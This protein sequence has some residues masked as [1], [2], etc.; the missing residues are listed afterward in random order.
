MTRLFINRRLLWATAALFLPWFMFSSFTFAEDDYRAAMVRAVAAKEKAL[1]SNL[2]QDWADALNRLKFADSIR[3]TAATKYEIGFAA[4]RLGQE[5]LAV[6]TYAIALELGL[7]GT[8]G[9]KARAYV[10]Y[11]SSKLAFLRVEGSDDTRIFVRGVERARL[12]H[13]SFIYVRPGSI[14]IEAITVT[15]EHIAKILTLTAG[16]VE[17]VSLNATQLAPS[18]NLPSTD[19]VSAIH[20]PVSRSNSATNTGVEGRSG[21]VS[22]QSRSNYADSNRAPFPQRRT[23]WLL[24]SAGTT[25]SVLSI[26]YIAISNRKVADSR[27]ALLVNCDLQV[28]GPDS[29]AHPKPGRKGDAQSA[30]DSIATWEMARTTSWVGLGAGLLTMIGGAVLLSVPNPEAPGSIPRVSLDP[31]FLELSYEGVF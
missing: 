16:Q 30:S 21:K 6:E 12:P 15:N 25:V 9:D 7:S 10:L 26:A 3:A 2:D 28:N 27:Q 31:H 1:H 24:L 17:S 8:A 23:G 4:A 13:A 29:C 14:A 22:H 11:H 5:D 18:S 19:E 20:Q